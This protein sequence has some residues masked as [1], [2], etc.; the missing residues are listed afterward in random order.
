MCVPCTLSGGAIRTW[1][2]SMRTLFGR[3]NKKTSGQV[4]KKLT[5]RQRWT[6][7]NFS[8]LSSHLV[9]QAQHSQLRKVPTPALPVD[10]E[11][12]DEGG[13][14]K[15][16]ISVASSQLPSSYQ[17]GPSQPRDRRPPR[18]GASGSGRKVND[19][20]VKLAERINANTVMQD[21][22]QSAVQESAKPCIAFC[23]WMG[24]EVSS[25]DGN[26]WLLFQWE[27]F[28]LV[29]RYH[30]QQTQQLAPPHPSPPPPAAVWL[31]PMLPQQE[32]SNNL[33]P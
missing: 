22:V 18:P 4:A 19:V 8:F 1:Y 13:D 21:R 28:D 15:D 25:L 16:A 27:A 31:P 23:Q 12:E 5:A 2:N 11:G 14:C 24:A 30:D 17:A 20:I 29:T 10:P 6:K 32:S 3:L 7:E 9:I 26:L 33:V